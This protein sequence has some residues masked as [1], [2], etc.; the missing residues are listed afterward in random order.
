MSMERVNLIISNLFFQEAI[1]KIEILE[2]DRIFCKHNIEHL[3]SVARIMMLI[4]IENQ[5]MFNKEL[6]YATA[7]LH[8]IGRVKEYENEVPHA[9]ASAELAEVILK[10]CNFNLEEIRLI[11]SAIAG[12]NSIGSSSKFGE[13]LK[14]S[15][16]LSRNC[17]ACSAINQCKWSKERLNETIKV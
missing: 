6:I 9:L 5:Y 1:N 4:N 12:H 16:K 13:L 7:L 11:T 17:F 2:Q 8:D 14:T 3:M 15:D 10:S